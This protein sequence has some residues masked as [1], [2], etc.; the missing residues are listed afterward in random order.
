MFK[1]SSLR[2][3]SEE[4]PGRPDVDAKAEAEAEGAEAGKQVR[5]RAHP[6]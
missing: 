1:D 2:C 5:H 3:E 6:L 4:E